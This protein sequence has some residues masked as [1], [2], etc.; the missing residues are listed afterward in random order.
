MARALK[1]ASDNPRVFAR[2]GYAIIIFSFGIVGGWAAMAPLGSAVVASGTVTAEG[3]RKT[4]QHLEGGLVSEIFIHEGDHVEA[5]QVLIRL[6]DTQPKANL[7]I[8][9][10]Q[11]FAAL[12]RETRLDAEVAGLPEV[13]FPDELMLASDPVAAKAIEDQVNQFQERR[14]TISGQISILRSRADQLRQEI[15]GLDRLKAANEEQ[16]KF[17]MDELVGVRMLLEKSL[18]PRSRWAALE[19]E[20]ARLE[21]EIGRAMSDHAK[22]EKSIGE[23][24]LQMSS[25][26]ATIPGASESGPS[27]EL[28][29]NCGICATDTLSRRTYFAASMRSH[30]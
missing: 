20:R 25:A 12:A 1:R 27:R 29:R 10:N 5:G 11:L 28:V 3:N 18:V 2:F 4:V 26:Q 23:N 7:E 17:I 19:R 16:V 14:A 6:D 30:R 13:K 22:A 9:R 8:S 24:Q 21:G 15:T